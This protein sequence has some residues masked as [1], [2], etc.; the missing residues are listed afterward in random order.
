MSCLLGSMHSLVASP[1]KSAYNAA[2]HGIAGF[3]KT[4][5]LETAQV[6]PG[7]TFHSCASPLLAAICSDFCVLIRA[8]EPPS[9]A[10]SGH[11]HIWHPVSDPTIVAD[12]GLRA[13]EPGSACRLAM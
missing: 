7:P 11:G 4:V 9:H 3:T 13:R 10:G 6:R 5:A 2:K 1:Y 8:R 12:P